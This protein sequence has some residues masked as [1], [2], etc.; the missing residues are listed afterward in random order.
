LPRPDRTGLDFNRCGTPLLEIVTEP[1]IA[2][3]GEAGLFLERLRTILRDTGVSD[4]DMEKGS[5]RAD[6]NVSL[7]TEAGP[8]GPRVE[9]K[10]LNSIRFVRRALAHEI[11]RQGACLEAGEALRQETRRWDEARGETQ[12][13]RGKEESEDYRYFPDPDLPPMAVDPA[14]IEEQRDFLPE[15]AHLRRDRF[16]EEL[17]L[18]VTDAHRLSCE[19]ELADYFELVAEV[20]GAPRAA[21]GWVLNELLPRLGRAEVPLAECPVDPE[22]LAGLVRRVESGELTHRA[23][24]QVLERIYESEEDPETAILALGLHDSPDEARLREA[25]AE[26]VRAHPD[27]V[28]Q[29]REGK[30]AVIEFLVGRSMAAAGGRADPRLLRELLE[31]RLRGEPAD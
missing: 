6:A 11:E 8:A 25:V 17:G 23:A 31:T 24:R 10:N 12:V 3:P 1:A 2:S 28:R 14:W 13:M 21:A 16:A 15:P 7:A 9:L 4:A 5:L 22:T 20:S 26:A 18:R 27:Q 29:Y 30:R 19:T